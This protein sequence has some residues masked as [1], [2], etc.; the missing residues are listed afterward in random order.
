MYVATFL[1]SPLST[2]LFLMNHK[3]HC[4]LINCFVFRVHSS[5][6]ARNDL[7]EFDFLINILPGNW[8]LVLI[9]SN[10]TLGLLDPPK[11]II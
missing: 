1:V 9:F 11:I 6:Q 7:V 3:F 2:G 4:F 5:K 8:V 10:P